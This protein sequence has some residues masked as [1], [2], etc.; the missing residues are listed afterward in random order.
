[1]DLSTVFLSYFKL[2]KDLIEKKRKNISS[3]TRFILLFF[4][5]WY[6]I[7]LTYTQFLD[8]NVLFHLSNW[9]SDKDLVRTF[10][11]QPIQ[12]SIEFILLIKI[13]L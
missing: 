9:R 4:F 11:W 1:M 10:L 3:S 12:V 13:N 2:V 5:T 8:S 7:T 6:F